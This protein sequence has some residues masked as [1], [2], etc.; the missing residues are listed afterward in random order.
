MKNLNIVPFFTIALLFTLVYTV[1]ANDGKYLEVMQKN[2]QAV[3]NAQSVEELQQV[4]NTFERIGGVEKTKWEPHY[5]S[6]FGYI[7]MANREKEGAKKD[8]YLDLA[9]G[10]IEKAKA[11]VQE[12][13]EVIALEGFAHMIRV[14]VDPG[15]R[16]PQFASLAMQSFGKAVALDPENPR[17]LSLM[18]QMQYGTAQFFGSS[19]A[20]ACDT[21]TKSLQKF[22]TFKSDNPLAPRWGKGMA[23]GLKSQCK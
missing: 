1:Q 23:E 15:S 9:M 13:S 14:T 12:E 4:V 21:I 6:A 16:G 8:S 7:M 5:Y 22:D 11:I 2:I 3:Y 10:A 18:A 20:E 19:T 17:A